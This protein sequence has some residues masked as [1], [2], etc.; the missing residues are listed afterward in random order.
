MV[1]PGYLKYRTVQYVRHTALEKRWIGQSDY[2]RF[3]VLGRSRVGSNLLRGLLNEHS[4]IVVFGEIFQNK[5]EIGWAMEGFPTDARTLAFFRHQPVQLLG[6]KLWRNYPND[7][8]A[9]GFKVFYYHARDPEWT[10]V[11]DY[12]QQDANL[13]VLHIKRRNLL[14][15][16]LSRKRAMLSAEWVNT[17]GSTVKVE[18][19]SLDYNECLADFE[20]TRT[21]E[22]EADSFFSQQAILELFYEDLAA[23]TEHEMGRIQEFLGV[24]DESVKPQTNK[25]R[26]RPLAEAIA[27]FQ[28]LKSQFAGSPWESFFDEEMTD[29]GDQKHSIG[30]SEV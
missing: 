9:V 7:I 30:K 26:K 19:I 15:V 21:W 11:W 23:D 13:H 2:T 16:H 17:G 4:Q 14:E 1:S 27:N 25:Q 6:Q 22:Q 12:L 18:A 29:F 5:N 10:A 24:N 3:I 20:Q 8:K 28:E